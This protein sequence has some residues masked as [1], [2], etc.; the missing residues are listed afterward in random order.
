MKRYRPFTRCNA[1]AFEQDHQAKPPSRASPYNS[2]QKFTKTVKKKLR[3]FFGN[4][5]LFDDVLSEFW[6]MA[7]KIRS[8]TDQNKIKKTKNEIK[9]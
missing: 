4:F 8:E 7:I 1:L 9:Q 2:L 5:I 3:C 6:C